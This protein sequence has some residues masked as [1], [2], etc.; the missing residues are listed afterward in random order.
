MNPGSEH[1]HASQAAVA[2][3]SAFA[4]R[5]RL[6]PVDRVERRIER[7]VLFEDT[8]PLDMRAG[9]LALDRLRR[10]FSELFD[11]AA[12]AVHRAGHDLDD[13]IVERYVVCRTMQDEETIIPMSSFVDS[14]PPSDNIRIAHRSITGVLVRVFLERWA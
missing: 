8:L 10:G 9:E 11:R 3:L 13:T 14:G 7:K 2:P 4:Q 12:L 5:V 6:D 1:G